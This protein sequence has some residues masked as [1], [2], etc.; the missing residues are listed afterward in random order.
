MELFSQQRIILYWRIF[1][2]KTVT[3][4][5]FITFICYLETLHMQQCDKDAQRVQLENVV[6]QSSGPCDFLSMDEPRW[7][8]SPKPAIGQQNFSNYFPWPPPW[9]GSLKLCRSI[10]TSCGTLLEEVNGKNAVFIQIMCV[11]LYEDA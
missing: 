10:S 7:L 9:K 1:I 8:W 4:H 3:W 6:S 11:V 5:I 2:R